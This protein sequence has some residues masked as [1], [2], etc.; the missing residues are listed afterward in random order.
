M[1]PQETK[2]DESNTRGGY[3]LLALFFAVAASAI[4]IALVAPVITSVNDGQVGAAEFWVASAIV[5]AVGMII[6]GFVGLYHYRRLFGAGLGIVTGA[7]IGSIVGPVAVSP[8]YQEVMA[9]CLGGS[10][11]LLVLGLLCRILDPPTPN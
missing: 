7:I 11:L 4:L 5:G 9:T 1:N 10:L 3:P 6:G 8:N 2:P